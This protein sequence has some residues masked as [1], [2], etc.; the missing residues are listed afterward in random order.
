M[1]SETDLYLACLWLMIA[2]LK[3]VI[4]LCLQPVQPLTAAAGRQTYSHDYSRLYQLWKDCSIY[5]NS[6]PLEILQG[7][8]IWI[9][10]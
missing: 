9:T 6:T 10:I 2:K 8:K 7:H 1:L 4:E 5:T 3:H